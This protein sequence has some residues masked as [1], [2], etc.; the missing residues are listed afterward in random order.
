MIYVTITDRDV[1]AASATIEDAMED[2]DEEEAT[3]K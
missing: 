3:R 1:V 2:E